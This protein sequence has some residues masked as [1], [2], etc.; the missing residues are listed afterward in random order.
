M[1]LACGLHARARACSSTGLCMTDRSWQ[2][3]QRLHAA[4]ACC[5]HPPH[6]APL[7]HSSH[8]MRPLHACSGACGSPVPRPVHPGLRHKGQKVL[9]QRGVALHSRAGDG[10]ARAYMLVR[11]RGRRLA[12]PAG[13]GQPRRMQGAKRGARARMQSRGLPISLE[14]IPA[15]HR[16]D[17]VLQGR[18]L[19]EAALLPL[20]L[21]AGAVGVC[22]R[23]A[24]RRAG[25]DRP[26]GARATRTGRQRTVVAARAP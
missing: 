25:G 7:R 8:S 3:M 26:P 21:L 6:A 14:G 16:E 11:G 5:M 10:R 2:S 17:Q 20:R 9:V 12:G 1:R 22:G 4:P 19:M 13:G 15:A 23:L 18:R 24:R